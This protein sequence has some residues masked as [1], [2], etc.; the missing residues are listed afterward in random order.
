MAAHLTGDA[1]KKDSVALPAAFHGL[2]IDSQGRQRIQDQN[3]TPP[4][5]PVLL[6]LAS[7]KLT[8][9]RAYFIVTGPKFSMSAATIAITRP[10]SS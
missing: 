7:L 5:V 6:H 4:I 1:S 8:D 2:V 3:D 9:F 10:T